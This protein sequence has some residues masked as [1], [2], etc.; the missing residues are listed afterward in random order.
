MEL[1]SITNLT[2]KKMENYILCWWPDDLGSFLNQSVGIIS[3]GIFLA[4]SKKYLP[5]IHGRKFSLPGTWNWDKDIVVQ[6]GIISGMGNVQTLRSFGSPTLPC[7]QCMR[8]SRFTN[9]KKSWKRRKSDEWRMHIIPSTPEHFPIPMCNPKAFLHA[10][11]FWN[12]FLL[13]RNTRFCFVL[14]GSAWLF[15]LSFLKLGFVTC[16]SRTEYPGLN[17]CWWRCACF[18]VNMRMSID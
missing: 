16:K 12:N 9:R 2:F 6:L 7:G 10:L 1:F 15:C 5:H 4:G 13:I 14:L 3:W 11:I 17:C 18:C 8:D